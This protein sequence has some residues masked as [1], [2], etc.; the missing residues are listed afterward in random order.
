MTE[1][2]RIAARAWLTWVAVAVAGTIGV[3]FGSHFLSP[4]IDGPPIQVLSSAL[5]DEPIHP[6]GALRF[7]I[8]TYVKPNLNCTGYLIREFSRR[9]TVNGKIEWEKHR[10]PMAP[11][12]LPEVAAGQARYVVVIDLMKY[13][14]VGQWR[15]RGR[16][17]LDCGFWHGGIQYLDTPDLFFDVVSP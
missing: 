8:D 9:I 14:G 5:L 16:T 12:P 15:F 17:V 10:A 4:L 1:C 6:G 3:I 2:M 7:E 13:I 11:P